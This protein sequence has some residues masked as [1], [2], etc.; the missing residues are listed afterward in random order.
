MH[1]HA[2]RRWRLRTAFVA[3]GLALGLSFLSA[4]PAIAAPTT[5]SISLTATP[6][7]QVGD[8]VDVAVGLVGAADVYAYELTL[9]FDPAVFSYVADSATGPAGGFDTVEQSDGSVTLVHTRLGSSPSLAG[10][11]AASV[12]L[13]TIG[14]GS[15]TASVDAS[16]VTLIDPSGATTV[17]TDAATA[18][19]A[20]AALPTPSPTATPDPT[21]SPTPTSGADVPP[22]TSTPAATGQ[23]DG[24]LALTGFGVAG[25]LLFAI[26]AVAVGLVVVRRRSAGAR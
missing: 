19:V 13:S 4:G 10:D 3:G 17:L 15:G 23:S 25:L 26:A 21:P 22:A 8:V 18:A 14:S 12:R 5:A 16:T 24:S 11:V 7:V 9:E 20:V 1:E 2:P 6:S